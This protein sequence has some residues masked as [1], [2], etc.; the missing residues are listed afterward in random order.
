M[1]GAKSLPTLYGKAYTWGTF[2]GRNASLIGLG[3][4][5]IGGAIIYN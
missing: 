2:Y 4:V 3:H 1:F 5:G